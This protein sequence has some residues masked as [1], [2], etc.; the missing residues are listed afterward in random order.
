MTR[1]LLAQNGIDWQRDVTIRVIPLEA[2]LTALSS[3]AV[4]ATVVNAPERALANKL[5]FNELAFYGDH[6]EYASGGI[7]GHRKGAD[8]AARF[9]HPILARIASNISMVQGQ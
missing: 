2:R 7:A 8:G 3:G 5:G 1:E 4:A 6:F 9:C